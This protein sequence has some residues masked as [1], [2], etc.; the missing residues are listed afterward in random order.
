MSVDQ[1]KAFVERM[2]SD[3]AFS[4]RVMAEEDVEARMALILAEGFDCSA[5]EIASLQELGDA[6]LD[7]VAG[8]SWGCDYTSCTDRCSPYRKA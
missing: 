4:A 3:E 7:A 5:E 1:A 8:G 2:K 6:E